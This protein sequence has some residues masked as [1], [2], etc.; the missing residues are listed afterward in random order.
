MQK[1]VELKLS[2]FHNQEMELERL[3]NKRQVKI[4]FMKE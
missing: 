3:I 1:F 2:D 4:D